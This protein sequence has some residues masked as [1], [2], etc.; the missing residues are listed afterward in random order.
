MGSEGEWF[1]A[2]SGRR[3]RRGYGGRVRAGLHVQPVLVRRAAAARVA[4]RADT[5]PEVRNAGVGITRAHLHH[6][7]Q[8][9][10]DG[11][12]L[13]RHRSGTVEDHVEIDAVHAVGWLDFLGDRPR[14]RHQ[15]GADHRQTQEHDPFHAETV[16]ALAGPGAK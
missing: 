9:V 14:S 2:A 13:W 4:H 7:G 16:E 10:L 5:G 12:D 6:G 1:V 3:F 11:L 8:V 15:G